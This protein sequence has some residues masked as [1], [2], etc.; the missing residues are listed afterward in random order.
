M[1][2][3]QVSHWWQELGPR[4]P[5]PD[6]PGNLD[7]DVAIVGAGYT[8]L[9]TAYYLKRA[10]PHLR[11]VVI[12]QRFAGYGA[13]GRNGGQL[14]N[15]IVG[16]REQYVADHGW[17]SAERF[18]L[19]MNEAVSEVIRVAH[20]ER[21]DAD[22][23]RGGEMQLAVTPAGEARLRAFAAAE[24][25]WRSS[26][27]EFLERA[28]AVG[29][30]D[31][32]DARAAVWHPHAARI[33]PA[34][35]VSGL[36]LAV[37]RL[38]VA[39]YERTRVVEI[40]PDTLRTTHGTVAANYIVR[41]TEGFTAQLPGLRRLWRPVSST[42]IATEPL[43]PEVWAKIGWNGGEVLGALTQMHVYAQRTADDR[44]VLGG[45][46]APAHLSVKTEADGATSEH[47]VRALSEAMR[48]MF[49]SA[50]GARIEQAWSGVL[51]VPRDGS[52][53]VGLD[54]RTGLAWAGGYA[55]TGVAAS[56]LAG[57]TLT[58]LILERETELVDLPWVNHR[59]R[60]WEP[61]MLGWI[62]ARKAL[63]PDHPVWG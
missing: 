16:G 2:N 17:D 38:G 48:R 52:A 24:R 55:G 23:H 30:I 7:V 45:G 62:T 5:R 19:A 6:L 44:I 9:W 39:I 63:R 34:K 33:H 25:R 22:I 51:A 59:A 28:D 61:E 4:V 42:L 13:S 60:K 20:S 35:L 56:N 49:P 27:L 50:G 43:G 15:T 57:R 26:D 29:R 32:A 41:A 46:G 40:A 53:G 10:Q 14:T 37:E 8:G 54:H 47:A 31:V 58:D 12:E 1:I 18:Q 3:A 21:I 11:I 36:A